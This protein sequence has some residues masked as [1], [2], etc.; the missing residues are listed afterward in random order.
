RQVL[1][2]RKVVAATRPS[3]FNKAM[4]RRS[5]LVT[6]VALGLLLPVMAGAEPETW[7]LWLHLEGV[8]DVGGPRSD[9]RLV[10]MASGKLFL[11]APDGAMAPFARGDDGYAGSADA[12]PYFTVTPGTAFQ[13]KDCAF[14]PD[15]V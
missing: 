10:A 4:S 11:V 5:L 14:Q 13:S 1:C 8:V 3:R 12:E 6:L 9:G 7:E 15:D 2:D